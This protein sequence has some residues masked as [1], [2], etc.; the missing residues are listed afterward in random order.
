MHQRSSLRSWASRFDGTGN[1]LVQ[2]VH[3]GDAWMVAD[4]GSQSREKEG[5]CGLEREGSLVRDGERGWAGDGK[6]EP[7]PEQWRKGKLQACFGVRTRGRWVSL[8]LMF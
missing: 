4:H 8:S 3:S 2:C 5:D 1:S 7:S 6:R